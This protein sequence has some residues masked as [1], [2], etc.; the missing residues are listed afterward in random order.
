MTCST[1]SRPAP[2]ILSQPRGKEGLAI[3]G[4]DRYPR[5]PQ[6]N[7]GECPRQ[8]RDE[9]NAQLAKGGPLRPFVTSDFSRK[10]AAAV[11]A[12]ARIA[13]YVVRCCA[14]TTAPS[15]RLRGAVRAGA[16]GSNA[17]TGSRASSRRSPARTSPARPAAIRSSLGPIRTRAKQRPKGQGRRTR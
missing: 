7:A 3:P 17:T 13:D 4:T 9:L 5:I 12:D 10:M 15:R 2:A 6:G 11:A 1:P 14:A 16:G 8:T